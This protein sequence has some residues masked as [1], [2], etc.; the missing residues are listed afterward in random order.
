VAVSTNV[1]IAVIQLAAVC[2][3]NTHIFLA[4]ATDP[5]PRYGFE[6]C[7]RF[8]PFADLTDTELAAIDAPMRSFSA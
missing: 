7:L 3:I 5:R 4:I 2:G 1:F 6:P 8:R